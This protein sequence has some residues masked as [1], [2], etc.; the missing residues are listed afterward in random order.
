VDCFFYDVNPSWAGVRSSVLEP[1][2]DVAA[3]LPG[4]GRRDGQPLLIGPD[5]YPDARIDGFF[6]SA[7]MSNRAEA[8]NRKYAWAIRAWL[9]FL[10]ARGVAWDRARPVDVEAFKF[11]RRTDERNPGRVQGSTFGGDMAALCAFYDWTSC[12]FG[13]PSPIDK[14]SVVRDG[15]R[16][17]VA[18]VGPDYVRTADVKWLAP[19]AY[20]RWRDV[21]VLGL[22][23]DG[24]ERVPWRPRCEEREV[25]FLDGLWGTGLRLQEWASVLMVALRGGVTSGGARPSGSGPVRRSAGVSRRVVNA[26]SGTLGS[27]RPATC[28]CRYRV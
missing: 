8:T 26:G 7:R 10:L 19:D 2:G 5:G 21:G 9:N 6:S 1:F 4:G 11:W 25:A 3:W 13:V 18:D 12:R 16:R 15:V 23:P 27:S 28:G 20:R 14:H 24:R 22:L 17:E